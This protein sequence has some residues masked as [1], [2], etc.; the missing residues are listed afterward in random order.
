MRIWPG[1]RSLFIPGTVRTLILRSLR[2]LLARVEGSGAGTREEGGGS[3]KTEEEGEGWRE[4]EETAQQT[5]NT[6]P[7][8]FTAMRYSYLCL[9]D[10]IGG[11]SSTMCRPFQRAT[12]APFFFHGSACEEELRYL[13]GYRFSNSRRQSLDSFLSPSLGLFHNCVVLD[14]GG[15]GSIFVTDWT[16]QVTSVKKFFKIYFL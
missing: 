9:I 4:G 8:R 11:G 6:S 3:E 5:P 13:D 12:R 14:V 16:W 10:C 2:V 7:R 1:L 15:L